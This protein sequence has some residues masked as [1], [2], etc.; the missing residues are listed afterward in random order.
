M[1][2]LAPALGLKSGRP[3]GPG[4]GKG[5]DG[6]K[7]GLMAAGRNVAAWP[8]ALPGLGFPNERSKA[9][10]CRFCRYEANT[11]GSTALSGWSRITIDG[12]KCPLR[13]IPQLRGRRCSDCRG[14]V[15]LRAR[16]RAVDRAVPAGVEGTGGTGLSGRRF[17]TQAHWTVTVP[18]MS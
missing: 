6:G 16:L 14:A 9:W 10:I 17:S 15:V 11:F 8:T 13:L 5:P 1:P 4:G 3:T 7:G 18:S 12:M 2:V